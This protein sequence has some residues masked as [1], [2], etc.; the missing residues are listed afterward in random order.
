MTILSMNERLDIRDYAKLSLTELNIFEYKKSN[1]LFFVIDGCGYG[2][3][4]RSVYYAGEI[5]KIHNKCCKVIFVVPNETKYGN[6]VADGL[7]PK[8]SEET[9]KKQ[10]WT[11]KEDRSRLADVLEEIYLPDNVKVGFIRGHRDSLGLGRCYKN[12]ARVLQPKRSLSMTQW[13][14]FPDLKPKRKGKE[15]DYIVV[16]TTELNKTPVTREKDPI[17][18]EGQE[19]Y[20]RELEKRGH[21]IKR[22]SYRDSGKKIFE[23]IANAKMCIGYEGMGNLISRMFR[24]P[25]IVFSG[26]PLLSYVTSGHWAHITTSINEDIF[27]IDRII[28][29]QKHMREKSAFGEH[30]VEKANGLDAFTENEKK[31]FGVLDEII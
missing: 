6:M 17:G 2:D 10:I 8:F 12:V 4:I 23:T 25:I 3:I 24:K 11:H 28:H 16:W 15:E 13:L 18:W 31:Y 21:R 19:E 9:L 26:T 29:G 20:L 7:K 30:L 1:L 22:I 27:E 5:A 14:G